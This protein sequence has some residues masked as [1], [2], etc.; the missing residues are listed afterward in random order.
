M[1]KRINELFDIPEERLEELDVF[2]SFIGI[3]SLFYI[4]PS[5]LETIQVPEFQKSREKV[6]GHYEKIFSAINAS[7]VKGDRFWRATTNL[8]LTRENKMVHLGYATEGVTGHGIGRKMAEMLTESSKEIISKGVKD[9][10]IFELVGLFEEGVGPDCISD[11]TIKIIFDD[12]LS[13]S[14]RIAISL[15]LPKTE[16]VY[17]KIKYQIP[18]V[19]ELNRPVVF[20]PKSILRDIPVAL[21]WT[22]RDMVA[23][24]NEELRNEVNEKIG[25]TWKKARADCKKHD[26]RKVILDHPQLFDDLLK[27]YKEKA[28]EAYDFINDPN[29]EVYWYSILNEFFAQNKEEKNQEQ[30]KDLK[31][32]VDYICAR[33]KLYFENNNLDA[34]LW[35]EK[36]LR[37]ERNAQLIFFV[38][39]DI[40]CE[41]NNYDIS[42]EPNAGRGPVDFKISKGYHERAV[43]EIKFSSNPKLISGYLKQLQQYIISE[44]SKYATYLVFLVRDEDVDRI[45]QLRDIKSEHERGGQMTPDIIVIDARSKKSAS[46][47]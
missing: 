9:P 43:V 32:I 28:K 19:T 12:L 37:H 20:V 24:Y 27:Q 1:I 22:S 11:L 6:T 30:L 3:D 16:Y 44:K 41:V 2:N 31:K 34:I 13:Y 14:H 7:T 38:I 17:N 15:D 33:C 23:R 8:F 35:H 42:R 47:L 26:L 5:L 29:G 10:M 21:D 36:K 39:A 25:D 4:D 18:Y 40:I 45:N 46:K